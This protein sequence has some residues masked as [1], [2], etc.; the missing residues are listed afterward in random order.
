M[1]MIYFV[2]M[3]RYFIHFAVIVA[4]L[5]VVL[6]SCKEDEK[7]VPVTGVAINSTSSTLKNGQTLP[8]T[9]TVS[10]E[11]ATRKDVIWVSANTAVATVDADGRVAAVYPG[12]AKITVTTKEG[13]KTAAMIIT[14]E[15]AVPVTGISVNISAKTFFVGDSVILTP[16]L[17]PAGATIKNV[18]WT[19]NNPAVATIKVKNDGR[20]RVDG[21]SSGE[22]TIQVTTAD[23]AHTAEFVANVKLAA[24]SVKLD[25]TAL[26]LELGKVAQLTATVLPEKATNQKVAWESS[27]P[28]IADVDAYGK[29]T[30]IS[31]G[32]ATITVT[33]DDGAHTAK[34]EVK[35]VISVTGV[36]INYN[37]ATLQVDKSLTLIAIVDPDDATNKQLT[38]KSDHPEVATVTVVDEKVTVTAVATG[39]ALIT[40]TTTDGGKTAS[41]LITVID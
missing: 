39:E 2:T 35:V 20:V 13:Y 16:T 26:T 19:N 17:E 8:L 30:A 34:C 23:G 29:I 31:T 37:W 21:I 18:T 9:A 5:T 33:T 40:A 14:V 15:P 3:K 4:F 12:E 24:T 25:H 32:N 11:N 10:P 41:C 22:A 28:A 38:W 36:K 6:H 7:P 1:I 27:D